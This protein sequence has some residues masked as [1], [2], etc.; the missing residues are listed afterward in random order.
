ML[1]GLNKNCFCFKNTNYKGIGERLNVKLR[2]N[3]VFQ[4]VVNKAR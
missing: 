4:L 3:S 2:P 1:Q